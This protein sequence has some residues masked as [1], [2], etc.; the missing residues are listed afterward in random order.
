MELKYIRLVGFLRDFKLI[1]AGKVLIGLLNA[2]TGFLLAF[3]VA[4]AVNAVFNQQP[5]AALTPY[6]A[7]ALTAILL[8]AFLSRYH[9][10]YTKKMSAKVKGS[11]RGTL[12][13]KLMQMGPA[14]QNDKRSG[15]VQSLISDGVESLEAFL[16]NYI[17]QTVVVLI[18]VSM[19]IVYICTLDPLVG[20]LILASALLSVLVPHVFMPAV[21]RV[22]IEYWQ[23]YAHLN[24]QYIEAIQ[25]MSTL[26][27]FHAG[28]ATLARLKQDSDRFAQS[29][30]RNTG[31]SLADS[32][33]ITLFSVIG[34]SVSV[35]LAAWHTATGDLSPTHLLIILF[36][37]GEC[38]KPLSDLNTYWH[39][40]YLGFSVAKQL[41][42]VLDA[43]LHPARSPQSSG[44]VVPRKTPLS[45]Q[46][47]GVTF[48]YSEDA[49]DA[50]DGVTL[51]IAP[52]ETVAI[53][54]KSGSGKSTIVNLLLRYF[55]VDEGAVS[56]DGQDI[57]RFSPEYL[58]SLVAVVFQDTYL[59]YGTV[60]ENLR[61]AKPDASE[62]EMV[63]AAK[64]A[65]AHAFITGLPRSYDTLV[66]E[67]GAT[68]SGGERQ[69][70]AIARAILKNAPIL[71]LD[72]AT[73]SVDVAT[74]RE[75]QQTLEGLMKNRTTIVIAH[76]LATVAGAER[77][78]VLSEGK[79]LEQGSHK[80]L[81]E[82][83][84]E[85]AH[86]VRMQ[87]KAGSVG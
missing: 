77:I 79:L 81:L 57:R 40:S 22:M 82:K 29:S 23:D 75:I 9:E 51:N 14:Y 43:P 27:A 72:E 66:G 60:A 70:I 19:V 2:G 42:A 35:A 63:A 17:P 47:D 38:M 41:Y 84:G 68:L 67:R 73:S 59:F 71:V 1:V 21:N 8:R 65:G 15:N 10:G 20:L 6:L 39:A 3:M 28:K 37:A 85:Y 44:A 26:K 62:E 13:D 11:I 86:L 69:R 61:M 16:V 50:L 53:V 4:R 80:T 7:G 56:I 36:L 76:R 64:A 55:D 74:E 30:I 46:L 33:L 45:V 52:G 78:F 58:R 31:L 48:R 12:L 54:G 5:F 24:A 34:T 32:G 87:R 25:G 49:R 83:D 18:S